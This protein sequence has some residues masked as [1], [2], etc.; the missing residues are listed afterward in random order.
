M[1]DS[2]HLHDIA[3]NEKRALMKR[4]DWFITMNSLLVLTILVTGVLDFD[5]IPLVF[6]SIALVTL[7]LSAF[8]S[9]RRQK[10]MK[11]MSYRA[12]AILV[13]LAIFAG[14]LIC[15]Y[16]YPVYAVILTG[17]ICLPMANII[18]FLKIKKA[19]EAISQEHKQSVQ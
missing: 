3:E 16:R 1:S 11:P 6:A 4:K 12:N 2:N 8:I 19:K 10:P 14:L 18:M 9:A 13:N 5:I 7:N 15:L 17:A